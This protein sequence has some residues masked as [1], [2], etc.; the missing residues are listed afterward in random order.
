MTVQRTGPYV[1]NRLDSLLRIERVNKIEAAHRQLKTAC[2]LFFQDEDSVSVHTLAWAAHEILDRNPKSAGSLL[3]D[4][5]NESPEAKTAHAELTEARNFFKH[6]QN[7]PLRTIQFIENLNEWLLIDCGQMYRS[8]TG[9]VIKEVCAVNVWVSVKRN[10]LI[11]NNPMV[12]E[13]MKQLNLP[14]NQF[15]EALLARAEFIGPNFV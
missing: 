3:I 1:A 14:K 7:K 10:I 2:R 15:L 13:Y 8:I 4:I 11:F 5:A 12:V 9:N 6:Y